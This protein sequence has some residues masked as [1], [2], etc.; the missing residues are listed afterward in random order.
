MNSDAKAKDSVPDHMV[1][2]R[3]TPNEKQPSS[4]KPSRGALQST[5]S[6]SAEGACVPDVLE[7]DNVPE[8]ERVIDDSEIL[9]F[10][11]LLKTVMVA[12]SIETQV[13][14][15]YVFE[16][17]AV[18]VDLSDI[19]FEDIQCAKYGDAKVRFY[20]GLPNLAVFMLIFSQFVKHSAEKMRYWHGEKRSSVPQADLQKRGKERKLRTVMNFLWC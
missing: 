13:G 18:Q 11:K 10:Q 16:D 12:E 14:S 15:S 1:L 20:T 2:T 19:A 3:P 6:N 5:R 7:L 4:T 8:E 17:K 9:V